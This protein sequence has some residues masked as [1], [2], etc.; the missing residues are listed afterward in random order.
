V[1]KYHALAIDQMC[2]CFQA[3][4]DRLAGILT[5]LI[6]DLEDCRQLKHSGVSFC[7]GGASILEKWIDLLQPIY[8]QSFG[9]KSRCALFTKRRIT[10]FRVLVVITPTNANFNKGAAQAALVPASRTPEFESGIS[11]VQGRERPASVLPDHPV[12]QDLVEVRARVRHD[13][14][15]NLVTQDTLPFNAILATIDGNFFIPLLDLEVNV[16]A[17]QAGL[18]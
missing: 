17:D 3:E 2:D 10:I 7:V 5:S 15:R 13:D 8:A 9:D 1:L 6:H 11:C 4:V 14:A 16:L 18:K 12:R